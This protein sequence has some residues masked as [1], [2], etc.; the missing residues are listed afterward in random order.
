[1]ETEAGG[2]FFDEFGEAEVLDDDGIDAAVLEVE[3]LGFGVREFGGEDEGVEGDVTFDA[4]GVEEGHEAGEVFLGEVVG[5]QAGIEP[6]HAEKDGVGTVGD[7]GAG[8]VPVA[9]GGEEFGERGHEGRGW[10]R[11]AYGAWLAMGDLGGGE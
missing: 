3:E 5:A 10:G 4:M 9:G 1:M 11:F 7:G 6:G 2:D 8:T